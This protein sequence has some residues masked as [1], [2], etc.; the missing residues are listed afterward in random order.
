[1]SNLYNVTESRTVVASLVVMFVMG[2]STLSGLTR[3]SVQ[4][5]CSRS[6][7]YAQPFPVKAVIEFVPKLAEQNDG[8]THPLEDTRG[9]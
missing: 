3:S 6:D 1:M 7:V 9:Y 2:S 5:S 4:G 8:E